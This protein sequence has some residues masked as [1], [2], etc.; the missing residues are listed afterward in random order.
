MS[1]EIERGEW[2]DLVGFLSNGNVRRTP[3]GT[4][5]PC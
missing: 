3:D 5:I 1:I 2:E 4:A